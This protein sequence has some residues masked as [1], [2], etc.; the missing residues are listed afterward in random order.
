MQISVRLFRLATTY[1]AVGLVCVV[2]WLWRSVSFNTCEVRGTPP[3][4]ILAV[5]QQ[6]CDPPFWVWRAS[7]GQGKRTYSRILRYLQALRHLAVGGLGCGGAASQRA[8]AATASPLC[9]EAGPTRLATQAAALANWPMQQTSR[10][11]AV[12]IIYWMNRTQ[13]AALNSTSVSPAIVALW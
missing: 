5:L 12:A 13:T 2:A 10:S 7:A 3:C 8:G 11:V 1:R 4:M 6:W 9:E